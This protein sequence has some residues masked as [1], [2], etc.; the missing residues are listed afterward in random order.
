M[1]YQNYRWHY[2]CVNGYKI[3][4]AVSEKDA[5]TAMMSSYTMNTHKNLKGD[6]FVD[7]VYVGSESLA[8]GVKGA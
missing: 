5:D 2:L 8:Q 6:W 3:M 1:Y 4:A 7:A